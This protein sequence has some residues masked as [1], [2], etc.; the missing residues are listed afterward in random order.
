[1][2][3]WEKNEQGRGSLLKGNVHL[4]PVFSSCNS[5]PASGLTPKGPISRCLV[6]LKVAD[7]EKLATDAGFKPATL[8]VLC[9]IQ[10]R[11][12]QRFFKLRFRQ[13]PAA[14]MRELRC[15]RAAALI[16]SGYFTKDAA[17]ELGYANSSHFCHEF[18]KVY[19]VSPQTYA[20]CGGQG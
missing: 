15:G 9:S 7:W 3:G 6:E 19:G 8:A 2:R 14:W 11:L 12:L 17:T 16:S 13:S 10:V 20:S 5:A 18:K 4:D 1:M